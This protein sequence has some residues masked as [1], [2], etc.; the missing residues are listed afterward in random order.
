MIETACACGGALRADESQTNQPQSCAACG[1]AS[2]YVTGEQLPP[3]AGAGDF[4]GVLVLES[5]DAGG[6]LL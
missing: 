5:Q 6:A 4:D 1:A 2:F 3:G